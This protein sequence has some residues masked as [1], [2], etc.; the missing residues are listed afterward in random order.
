MLP[1]SSSKVRP[2]CLYSTALSLKSM[3][4]AIVSY[5]LFASIYLTIVAYVWGK[6]DLKTARQLRK[7]LEEHGV[8]HD[9]I[10]HDERD[11]FVFA[12]AG[13]TTSCGKRY[14]QGVEGS[15]CRLHH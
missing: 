12:F 7:R 10:A 3:P 4:Y 9:R 8:S 11:S 14:T 13:V 1:Y 15:N 5:R 6:R 2:F